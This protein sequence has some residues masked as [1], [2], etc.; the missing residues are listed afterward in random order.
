[1]EIKVSR[2][3]AVF[4]MEQCIGETNG[5]MAAIPNNPGLCIAHKV[6][7]MPKFIDLLRAMADELDKKQP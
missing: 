7:N 5:Q 3:M 2:E 6:D 4:F 1:M